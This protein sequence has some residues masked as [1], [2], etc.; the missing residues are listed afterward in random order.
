MLH[1]LN[2]KFEAFTAGGLSDSLTMPANIRQFSPL[3]VGYGLTQTKAKALPTDVPF[4]ELNLA[5]SGSLLDD[6]WGQLEQF[7][8]R[9]KTAAY[10]PYVGQWKSL[11]LFV[12]GN[13]MFSCC[14]ET[15]RNPETG[16]HRSDPVYVNNV[17][18]NVLQRL[19]DELPRDTNG[20]HNILITV[21]TIF[22]KPSTI[23][24]VTQGDFWCDKVHEIANLVPC[25]FG[26][27]Q[28][29]L[30]QID[31]LAEQY[32]NL[33][34]SL[35]REWQ[36]KLRQTNDTRFRVIVNRAMENLDIGDLGKEFI[37]GAD[38]FHP[39]ICF[40]RLMTYGLWQSMTVGG[41]GRT[42]SPY[43]YRQPITWNTCEEYDASPILELS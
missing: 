7:L 29:V 26:S 28:T 35:V 38:C 17:L 30:D 23:A 36:Q 13:N 6:V 40:H 18:N 34:I 5:V 3:M 16:I 43:W 32:N 4:N 39:N 20:N 41:Q 27:N 14:I 9:L 24:S 37:N 12:K 33:T 2:L 31:T 22:K 42:R 15:L 19:Y 21:F 25:L 1:V 10:E 11:Q 8:S